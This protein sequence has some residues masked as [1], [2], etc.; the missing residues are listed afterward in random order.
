MSALVTLY[1][2]ELCPFC[3]KVRAALEL[4]GISYQKVEVSPMD[5][6]GLPPLPPE[7]PRKVPVMRSG[8]RI[9]WDSSEILQRI[10]ELAPEGVSLVPDDSPQQTRAIEL[11]RWISD[12]LIAALPTV[13]YGSWRDAARAARIT[14]AGS[15]F[16]LLQGVGVR[17]GGS[18]IMRQI[19]KRILKRH[20]RRDGEAWIEELVDQ[21]EQWLGDG[22]FLQGEKLTIADAAAHGAFSCVA[23]FPV[24]ERTMQRPR[25]RAWYDR[26]QAL[27]E[28]Q[29]KAA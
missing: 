21:I 11:D 23:D 7:A 20:G 22:E 24:F 16:N 13:I 6:K 15:N 18:L 2:F 1:Q 27:R 3:H 14:A 9:I 19:A 26:V 17:V 25:L 12:N 8:E 5:K 28:G 10:D 4:K 29:P